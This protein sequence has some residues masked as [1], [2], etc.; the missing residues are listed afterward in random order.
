LGIV[1]F[2]DGFTGLVGDS[3]TSMQFTCTRL[4]F[5]GSGQA[6]IDIEASAISPTI[7]KTYAAPA[8]Y[9]GLYLIGSAIATLNVMGNSNVG[10]AIKETQTSTVTTARC[11]GSA[12]LRLSN[13]VSL[14]TAYQTGGTM[15]VDCA[16]TTVTTYGGKCFTREVGEITTINNRGAELYP[17]S[18]GTVTTLNADAGVTDF[19]TSSAA[20]TVTTFKQNPG[21]TVAYDPAVLTITTRSAP[22]YPIR[23]AGTKP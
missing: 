11:I 7:K 4:D 18:I 14:T 9:H 6:Y 19:T 20:R 1:I 5:A 8:G 2:E 15:Y 17:N 23:L 21:A 22:D 13:G 10:V 3:T 16:A 12:T